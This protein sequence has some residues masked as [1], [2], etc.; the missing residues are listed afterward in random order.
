MPATFDLAARFKADYVAPR[1]PVLVT[2]P[3]ARYLSDPHRVAPAKLRTILR[4]R[5]R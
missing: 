1:R 5:V 4:Y 3:R 2:I